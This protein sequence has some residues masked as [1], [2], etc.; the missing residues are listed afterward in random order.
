MT[1]HNIDISPW[2]TLYINLFKERKA[3]KKK[4][5]ENGKQEEWKAGVNGERIK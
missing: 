4:E 5:K 3:W 1:S 2:D